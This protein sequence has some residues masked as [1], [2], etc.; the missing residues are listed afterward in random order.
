MKKCEKKETTADM[1][2]RLEA[3]SLQTIDNELS[4]FSDRRAIEILADTACRYSLRQ[5]KQAKHRIPNDSGL[6]GDYR[7]AAFLTAAEGALRTTL[8]NWED[9]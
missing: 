4:Q 2:K 9:M 8:E 1:V 7:R 3:E 5:M 6:F